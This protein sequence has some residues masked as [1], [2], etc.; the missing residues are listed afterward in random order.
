MTAHRLNSGGR[1]IDRSKP[2][3][4]RFDGAELQGF[5]GDT[6]ASA[7]LA[8]GKTL[9]GRSFK[10]HRPR[11]LV[12]AGVEEPNALMTV[13]EGPRATPNERATMV[14]LRDGLTAQSQNRWPSLEFDVGAINAA[15]ASVAPVFPA[16]FYYKTF[17]FPRVAW[18]HLYEPVIRRAAGLGRAPEGPDPDAYEHSYA[19]A[20]ILVIGAGP[21]GLAAARAAAER[22]ARVLLVEQAPAPGGRLLVE[23]DVTVDGLPGAEWA[24][25]EAAALAAMANVTILT[26]TEGAGL[27]DHGYALLEERRDE[28][29]V[30]RLW[31]VRAKRIVV[32]TGAIERPLT[33]ANNDLPGVMLAGAVRD[34]LALWGVA[35]GREVVVFT[36]NDDGY[37][38]ALAAHAA[39]LSVKAVVD[40]RAEAAGA[41]PEAARAAGLRVMTGMVVAKASGGKALRS[42]LVARAFEGR[43]GA[44]REEIGCDLLAMSG[45]WSPAVHLFSHTGGKLRWDDDQAMFRPAPERAA[46]IGPDGEVNTFVAGTA[47]G[48]LGTAEAL[49]DA[50][51]DG[52]RAAAGAGFDGPAPTAPAVEEAGSEPLK[53]LWFSP[54]PGKYAHGTKHFLDYQND[55]TAADVELAAREGYESVEHAKRYTTLGMATDQGKLSNVNGL[56]V[57]AG[58]LGAQIPAVGTTTFRPPWTPLSFGAVVGLEAGERFKPVRRTPIQDWHEANHAEF[59]PVG[60][61]R[62]PFC[63]RP[64]GEGR[65]AAVK[66][67]VMAVRN[68]VG[69]LDASTLGKIL[70]KGPDAGRFLD[71]LY[72]NV[73]SSLK[74][75]ACRYGLMCNENGFLFDDG[76]VARLSEDEFLCHTTTGGADRVHGWMEEWLQ[77]EW[78]ELKVYVANLTEQ[79][80]QIAVAGPKAR[81]VLAALTDMELS[82]EAFP[83]LRLKEGEMAGVPVRVFRISFSGELSY[84]IAAPAHRGRA[85]W[86]AL[87]KAGAA[88]GI[89]PYG[90]EALHVLR[91]EKGYIMIGDETDGTVTPQDLGLSWA[92]S[93][94]KADFIGKR[95]QERSF[96][97]AP[98]RWRLVG[99]EVLDPSKRLPD[100]AYAAAD[101]AAE[102]P[103]LIGR[104]TS[105][106][107]SPTLGRPIA[108]GLVRHGP[109]RMGE[110]IDFPV[111]KGEVMKARIVDPVFY[112]REGVRLNG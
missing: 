9:L 48:Y 7:L 101:G 95:A 45:G 56:A 19:F 38:T 8:N 86:D 98:D 50:V 76:V 28:A 66:R 58:T 85:L 92:V 62:R 103:E 29:P 83:F 4:F 60:D 53:P 75:G 88:H 51:E 68:G 11:G 63:Y 106:Y 13:G 17:I 18:K 27:Y 22:G 105:S 49:A 69:I 31:R 12:A 81:E 46:P 96:L 1:L 77:T 99:L 15:I 54:G 109:E 3:R 112:D 35:P 47:D 90:T 104:V 78:P 87:L 55:V 26:R 102:R 70:V 67:E 37:R 10:Y 2:V 94:K 41:L 21:A 64:G 84:E 82:A 65:E 61:W 30:R 6:L 33:F 91:A 52:A 36:N 44:G 14:P 107:M 32:A 5:A 80:A 39:G 40:P 43:L 20:D 24:A 93:K 100:G 16:G 34:Y 110:V 74:P 23:A 111:A 57:L 73:M 71:M 108:L 25:R 59:E 42:V 72:T 79:F 89:T 97:T